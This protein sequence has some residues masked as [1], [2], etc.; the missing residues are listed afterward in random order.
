MPLELL[1]EVNRI[2]PVLYLKHFQ[3]FV[4]SGRYEHLGRNVI[5]QR[6]TPRAPQLVADYRLEILIHHKELSVL[7]SG[8]THA[9]ASQVRDFADVVY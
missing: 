3:L 1:L 4:I 9:Q 2:R 5:M 7:L 8:V 6:M